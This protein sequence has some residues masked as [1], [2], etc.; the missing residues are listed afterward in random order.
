MKIQLASD[1]HLEFLQRDWPGER[2]IAPVPGVDVLVLAGDI[3]N[4]T[5]AFGLFSD[6]PSLPNR[7]PIVY[8]GGNHELYGHMME[9]ML[10]K[11]KRVAPLH[12][13]HFLE[14]DSIEIGDVRILGATLWT[15][16]KL[17]SDLSQA[18]QMEAAERGLSDHRMIRNVR[19]RFT[20][21]DALDRHLDSRDWL[22]EELAK[23][24]DG[25]TV[26]VTHHGPHRMSTHARY[27]NNPL[28][29]GFVSDLS[30]I[31][32]SPT[33]PDLWLHGHVHDGFDY[34]VGRTRVVANPAGYVR[35]RHMAVGRTDFEFENETFNPK[36]VLEV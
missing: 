28:N 10:K 6:W 32:Y 7:V 23:P 4:G 34:T 22:I 35:N 3:A 2:I 18:Q 26:V 1:L 29:A 17:R 36:M 15:N 13:V 11:M 16:Y 24:W 30:E 31:L 25:K 8:V 20:A 14:N 19:K 21:Q 33:A 5:E 12:N 9:P 27:F